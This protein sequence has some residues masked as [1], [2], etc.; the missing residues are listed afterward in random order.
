[1]LEREQ[2]ASF[3]AAA[4]RWGQSP[5]SAVQ[6][7]NTT[8]LPLPRTRLVGRDDD[9]SMVIDMLHHER[10]RLLTLSGPAGVGQTRL[11]IAAASR[12]H[13]AFADGIVFV[14]LAP[15]RAPSLVL[16]T[17]AAGLGLKDQ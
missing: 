13:D 14:D 8:P 11:A 15:V 3:L 12:L 6:L 9:L 10:T 4:R 7:Q 2:R 16:S 1:D 17:I 5:R